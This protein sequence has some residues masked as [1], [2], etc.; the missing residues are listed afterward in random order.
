MAGKFV[1]TKDKRGEYRFALKAGNGETIAVSE[2]YKTKAS[3]LNGVDSVRRN[4]ADAP[5][6]D[7]TEANA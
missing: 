6:D 3:A 4:A 1:I 7:T 5:V 2:G